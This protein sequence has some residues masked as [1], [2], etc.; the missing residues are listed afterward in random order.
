MIASAPTL[1]VRMIRV[2]RKSTT[3]PFE[4]VRRPSSSTKQDIEY[5]RVRLLDF[6]E[7]DN[8]IRLATHFLGQ[9]TAFLVADIS[10]RRSD[11]T[12]RGML[13]HV[14]GHVD[15]HDRILISEHG[16]GKSSCQLGFTYPGR[17]Q[18]DEGAHWALRIL[19]SCA[20]PANRTADGFDGFLLADHAAV[21]NFFQIQKTLGLFFL[22][23]IDGNTGPVGD[24]VGDV[25][26]RYLGIGTSLFFFPLILRDFEL[27]AKLLL[28][29]AQRCRFLE[30]LAFG[31]PRLSPCG[32]PPDAL[33][34]LSDLAV[35]YTYE[36]EL[37]NRPRQ[38]GQSLYPA[39]SGP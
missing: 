11:E 18:E 1:E 33:P 10:R 23:F 38:S 31:R 15:P 6:I 24:N 4:S 28:R 37:S 26:R 13:L 20:C 22:Q 5:F 3:R 30:F 17:T 32:Y 12:R 39:G 7:E 36:D 14:L 35:W 29:I 19:Q 27:L 25:L 34:D 8:G 2:F 21:K 9:L 16:L